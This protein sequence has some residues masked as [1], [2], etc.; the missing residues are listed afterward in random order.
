MGI[1]NFKKKKV[2]KRREQLCQE[3][4][5]FIQ[6]HFVRES[7]TDAKHKY[8]TLSLKSDPD[9][10]ACLEWYASH[11]NPETFSDIVSAYLKDND[12]N[13]GTLCDKF[14]L[15]KNFFTN[16]RSDKKYHPSKGE[17]VLVA[18]AFKLNLEETK[19]LL[20][21]AEHSLSNSSKSDLI[22]R[23]FIDKKEYNV[24][25]LN[26]VL[27]KFCELKIKDLV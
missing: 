2:K 6:V 12:K 13:E 17:A 9:R 21:S 24:G 25:D 11:N 7:P 19:A 1:F 14:Q 26:Y 22:I 5:I 8:N 18:F 15:E 3:A 27:D 4:E 16:L 20:K 23:F 10:D